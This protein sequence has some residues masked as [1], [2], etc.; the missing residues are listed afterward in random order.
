MDLTSVD[1]V[2][3]QKNC[4]KICIGAFLSLGLCLQLAIYDFYINARS[5]K[6]LQITYV[7]IFCDA[8]ILTATI[9]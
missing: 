5:K 6:S 9:V 3:K 1:A 8:D 7:S 2:R 4:E